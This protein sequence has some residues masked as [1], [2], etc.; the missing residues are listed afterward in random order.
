MY[1]KIEGYSNY[2]KMFIVCV[3]T[4]FAD[5]LF[6]PFLIAF[7]FDMGGMALMGSGLG[8]SMI[9]DSFG[10]YFAGKLSDKYGR[11]PFLLISL[12]VSVFVFLAFP[13]IVI[14]EINPVI[15]VSGII[16]LLII[17]G[18]TSGMW[19]TVEAIYLGDITHIAYRGRMMGTYWG[20]SGIIFGFAMIGAGLLG[21]HI[22]FLLIAIVVALIYLVAIALLFK[23][24]DIVNIQE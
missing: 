6:H 10:A 1:K 8:I 5:G 23:I 2:K 13:L 21:V 19:D 22:D 11:K 24:K 9:A 7:L 18:L 16:I 17:S 20:A 4:A 3:L 15:I 14:I 12:I